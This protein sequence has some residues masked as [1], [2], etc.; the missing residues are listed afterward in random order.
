M[1]T[2]IYHSKVLEANHGAP[3]VEIDTQPAAFPWGV[4][5]G[6]VVAPRKGMGM[7]A[8][9]GPVS[10]VSGIVALVSMG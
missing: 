1:R 4:G 7:G 2:L 5:P 10:S 6:L 8:G 9:T 3:L